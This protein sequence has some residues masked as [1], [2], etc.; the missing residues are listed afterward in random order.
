MV[1]MKRSWRKGRATHCLEQEED[2][3][4][5]ELRREEGWWTGE[6]ATGFLTAGL[7]GSSLL[8]KPSYCLPIVHRNKII[9]YTGAQGQLY[10]RK[11]K[12]FRSLNLSIT[13][14][15]IAN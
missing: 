8:C 5:L 11:Q 4:C 3:P 7:L 10:K 9:L 6:A 1:L 14:K 13:E 15:L 2:P 12:H